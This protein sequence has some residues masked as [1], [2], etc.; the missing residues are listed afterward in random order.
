MKKSLILL[1]ILLSLPVH[2]E[3]TTPSMQLI[4]NQFAGAN[5]TDMNPEDYTDKIE[6]TIYQS[7]DRLIVIQ[8]IPIKY[9]KQATEPNIQ[10]TINDFPSF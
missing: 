9:I 6:N 1:I 8:S 3:E 7:G 5:P 10:P 4:T 2:A